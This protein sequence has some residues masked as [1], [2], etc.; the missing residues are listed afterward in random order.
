MRAVF[1][2]ISAVR[3]SRLSQL[4]LTAFVLATALLSACGGGNND[5][6][7]TASTGTGITSP[8]TPDPVTPTDPAPTT[9]PPTASAGSIT[10]SWVAPATNAD[11]TPVSDLAGYRVY[12]GNA[13][14]NY[15]DNVTVSGPS[16]LTTTISNLPASTYYVV[17]RAFNTVNMESQ[18]SMEVSKTIR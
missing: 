3:L 9:P 6:T 18:A 8:T 10:L 2:Q 1:D 5:P 17:V 13:S 14:G 15:S 4:S 7:S 16:T 11:G 12:Y